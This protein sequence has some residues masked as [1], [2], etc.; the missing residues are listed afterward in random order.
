[1]SLVIASTTDTQ[2]QVNEA[3]G[4]TTPPAVP[5]SEAP[6]ETTQ[7]GETES[8]TESDTAEDTPDSEDSEESPQ[9]AKHPN[10]Q[11]RI[12]RLV[13]EKY[14]AIG[15]VQELERQLA[16]SRPP[17]Q[18]GPPPA[19]PQ[20]QQQYTGRPVE[21][22]YER[23]EDYIE[24]LTDFKTAQAYQRIQQETEQRQV[25]QRQQALQSEWQSRVQAYKAQAPDFE[26]VLSDAEDIQLSPALQQAILEHE[27]GPRL[28]YEL[29]KDRKTLERIAKLPPASAIRELGKFEALNLNGDTK[30]PAISKAP[31]PISP[32][33]TGSTKST[34]SPDEMTHKEY[35]AWR[36]KN[37]AYWK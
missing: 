3:A 1:M 37:G 35:R 11:R 32:V 15:R 30:A 16:G 20:T 14:Q 27:A 18:S 22:Q 7:D 12:D 17:Q 6:P 13:R 33:G 26:S 19:P 25:Q 5:P 29:A 36:I 34:K 24:A 4:V 21:S 10:V 9:K 8:A 31:P 28:A 23:Y 2:A